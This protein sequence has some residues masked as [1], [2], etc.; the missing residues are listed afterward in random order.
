[1]KLLYL[2]QG[3]IEMTLSMLEFEDAKDKVSMGAERKSMVIPESEKRRTAYHE[4]GHAIVASVLPES[5]S[6]HK[7]TIIPRGQALGVTQMFPNEDRLGATDIQLR[8]KLAVFMGGRAAEELV[9]NEITTGAQNDIQQATRIA[10]AMVTEYG[11]SERL[12][13]VNFGGQEEIFVGR[14]YGQVRDHSEET[15]QLIDSE[16]RTLL[17]DAYKIATQ[18]LTTNRELLNRIAER[19][20][21]KETLNHQEFQHLIEGI[22]SFNLLDPHQI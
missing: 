10:R 1:M 7:V 6:V 18:I 20:L 19:L 4:A 11:M 17:E 13:P 2:L 3:A 16:V 22:P 12:G 8:T 14:N 15:S 21:E 9:F 5:D